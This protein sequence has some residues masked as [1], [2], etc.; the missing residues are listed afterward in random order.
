MSLMLPL[1]AQLLSLDIESGTAKF[2]FF[3]AGESE[4][5][6]ETVHAGEPLVIG[7][8]R[9]ALLGYDYDQRNLQ[10]ALKKA[11]EKT[12]EPVGA[13]GG[14]V[15]FELDG[16]LF[17]I[18]NITRNYLGVMGPAAQLADADDKLFWVFQ[19]EPNDLQMTRQISIS[20]ISTA[21]LALFAI[22][23]AGTG[24][25]LG[26]VAA[27]FFLLGMALFIGFP[28]PDDDSL[29]ESGRRREEAT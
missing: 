7:D 27:I 6:E 3:R 14:E 26:I 17:T 19:R 13:V 12:I 24:P 2:K 4:G 29:N 21:P 20:G 22:S 18:R 1:R 10:V 5:V 16:P 9:L 23:S 11:G 28:D 8:Y 25:D 15:Q